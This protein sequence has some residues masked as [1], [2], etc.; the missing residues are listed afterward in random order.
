RG[1]KGGTVAQE[2]LISADSHVA[3]THDHV[4]GH[5]HARHHAEY[6]EAVAEFQRRMMATMGAG[7]A[8]VM[9]LQDYKHPAAGRPGHS[10]A[11]ARLADMDTDGVDAEV[12]YCEVSA[13]RYLYLMQDAW[14]AATRAFND[15]LAAFG[16]V[17]PKRLVVSYQIPIHDIDAAVAE[18]HRVSALGAKSL[19]LPVF[20]A[21]LGLPD[22]YDERYGPLF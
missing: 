19:Q 9:S 13:F 2:R 22:Y 1:G 15:T 3:V 7:R 14:P 12:L 16:S 8:N 10:D 4:K 18:V 21:E 17:D 11:Q 6:D 5:L 20:P